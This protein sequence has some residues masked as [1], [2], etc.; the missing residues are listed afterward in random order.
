MVVWKSG[1][2]LLSGEGAR[3]QEKAAAHSH[4]V[5][6]VSQSY[7]D[8]FSFVFEFLES[9]VRRGNRLRG[10]IPIVKNIWR[11]FRTSNIYSECI[12]VLTVVFV[13]GG[14][15]T[16]ASSP[17]FYPSCLLLLARDSRIS[18]LCLFY[19]YLPALTLANAADVF[20]PETSSGQHHPFN[21]APS[22]FPLGET[23]SFFCLW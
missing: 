19:S 6:P 12:P 4:K 9:H 11:C 22:F 1:R 8:I 17:L 20:S 13:F 18:P 14:E 5:I 3:Q 15:I 2:E 23:S 10:Q 7:F 16:W 21:Y